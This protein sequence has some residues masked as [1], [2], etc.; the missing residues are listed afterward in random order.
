MTESP[1]VRLHLSA[2][3]SVL[4]LSIAVAKYSIAFGIEQG[5]PPCEWVSVTFFAFFIADGTS[6]D[7]ANV[8]LIILCL[9]NNYFSREKT[10]KII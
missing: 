1:N 6:F 4:I 7:N 8:L 10:I 5:E 3:N 2:N 9:K